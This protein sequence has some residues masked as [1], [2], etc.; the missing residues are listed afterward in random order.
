MAGVF[1]IISNS[2]HLAK[3]REALYTVECSRRVDGSDRYL[4]KDVAI[5]HIYQMPG[6]IS[7]GG[8][9]ITYCP[10]GTIW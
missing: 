3:E 4:A 1:S 8:S 5:E 2:Y 6:R 10:H 7:S 9:A